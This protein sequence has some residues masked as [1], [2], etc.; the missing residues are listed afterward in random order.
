MSWHPNWYIWLIIS[1]LIPN[2]LTIHWL[3]QPPKTISVHCL[4]DLCLWMLNSCPALYSLE[5]VQLVNT[6]LSSNPG[7]N[8]LFSYKQVVSWISTLCFCFWKILSLCVAEYEDAS[9]SSWVN[10]ERFQGYLQIDGFTLYELGETGGV[11]IKVVI[12]NMF[13]TLPNNIFI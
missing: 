13:F 6:D 8:T 1:G 11:C 4:T 3:F 5:S 9:L 2:L 10:K 12:H 7:T